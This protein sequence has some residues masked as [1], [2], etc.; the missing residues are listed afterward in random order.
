MSRRWF[1]VVIA[2]LGLLVFGGLEAHSCGSA[3]THVEL[4]A[5]PKT[6][7]SLRE[8]RGSA[9]DLEVAGDLEGL[10]AGSVR[11]VTREDLQG[12]PQVSYPVADDANFS[13]SVQ[14]RG[15]ELGIL[16][17]EFARGGEKALIVAVCGDFY[18]AHYPQAYVQ[19]HRPLLVLEIN[20]EAPS[21]WPKSK[22]GSAGMGPYLISHP[23]FTPSSRILGNKEE[24]QIPWGVVRL[25]FRSEEAVFGE[26]APRGPGA[27]EAAAQAGYRIAREN[28]LRCHGPASYGRLKGQIT[29]PG[30]AFFAD[31]SPRQFSAYVRN[32]R[33]V[34]Q[35]A[36]MPGN[37]G[38]DEATVQALIA[39]FGT[40]LAKEKP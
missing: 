36:Q 31:A 33:G 7:S 24:A 11:Y 2:S 28:C 10:P 37:P 35:Y 38:Y 26:I 14:V 40:F 4:G 29:W 22:E 20:G 1:G 34:A 27:G 16:A 5:R 18:R 6:G 12:L 19:T 23:H 25:E 17:R 15:V 3:L 32:P 39:Y 21:G 13:G 30:I 9:L 8:K